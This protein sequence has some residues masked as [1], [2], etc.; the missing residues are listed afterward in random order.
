VTEDEARPLGDWLRQRREELG[1]SLEQVEED[2][3]IRVRYL[4]ALEAEDLD[5]LP[6]PVVGRGFLRNYAAYLELD[7]QEAARR[8]SKYS[9]CGGLEPTPIQE[10]S[11]FTSQPFRPVPLHEM[12]GFIAR[13][14]LLVGLIV[15]LIAALSVL[16]WWGYPYVRDMLAL[17]LGRVVKATATATQQA[18]SGDFSTATPTPTVPVAVTTALPTATLVQATPTLELTLTPTFTPSPSPTPSPPIYTGI[19]LEL[20][21]SDTSWIQVTVDGVRQFQGELDAGTYKSWY[22]EERMELRIGNAGAVEVTVNGQ[23]LGMLG[24]PGEV[25][26]RVF[27]KIGEQVTETTATPQVTGTVAVTLTLTPTLR[28]TALPATTLPTLEPTPSSSPTA[29]PSATEPITPTASP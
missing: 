22:G 11:P 14:G 28:P 10:A 26:D 8:Y 7:P 12:P 15:I 23:K 29:S 25:V 6:D 24:A 5:A 9:P 3:R 4:Q 19:F 13:R 17:D 2:T 21:F 1:I 16:A 18:A 20:V 27:E